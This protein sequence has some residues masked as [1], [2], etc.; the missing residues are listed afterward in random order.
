MSAWCAERQYNDICVEVKD[1]MMDNLLYVH[2]PELQHT[3]LKWFCLPHGL[4]VQPNARHCL[5]LCAAP[6]G[7]HFLCL[8]FCSVLLATACQLSQFSDL[9]SCYHCLLCFSFCPMLFLCPLLTTLWACISSCSLSVSLMFL[10]A[11]SSFIVS[12]ISSSLSILLINCSLSC[13]SCSL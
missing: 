5:C 7:L 9:F 10:W 12:C 6:Q 4:H 8:T 2:P 1:R 13:V 3:A 11:V